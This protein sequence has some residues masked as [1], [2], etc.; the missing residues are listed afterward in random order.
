M[1]EA[2]IQTLAAKPSWIEGIS[3]G[4][5][6]QT[7]DARLCEDC[8]EH[9][10]RSC[11]GLGERIAQTIC[12]GWAGRLRS[13]IQTIPARRTICHQKE[14]L[15]YVPFICRGWASVSVVLPDGRRQILS[16]LLPGDFASSTAFFEPMWGRLIEAITEVSFRTF[17]REELRDAIFS[18]REFLEDVT[19]VWSAEKKH[20]DRLAVDLGRRNADERISG[21]ILDLFER[22]TKRGLTSGDSF[23]FP[24]RQRHI[25]DATGLTPVHVSK[26]LGQFQKAGVLRISERQLDILDL[27]GLRRLAG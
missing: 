19:K 5:A 25:A 26:I 23:D 16:F 14:A 6:G 22:L 27:P 8:A 1:A 2:S 12:A 21:L 9:G 18:D 10:R 20:A 3:S 15:E 17:R 24:L 4:S 11:S 13:S 7:I